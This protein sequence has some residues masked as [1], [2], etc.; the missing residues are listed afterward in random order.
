MAELA[1]FRPAEAL[2]ADE[3]LAAFV[4]HARDD[5][6]VF[7][8]DLD[9]NAPAWELRGVAKVSGRPNTRR[10]SWGHPLKKVPKSIE[11]YAALDDRNVDFFKAYMRYTYGLAPRMSPH[12]TLAAMRLLDKAFPAHIHESPLTDALFLL[13]S[14]SDEVTTT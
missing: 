14:K 7:G 3:R 5:L 4:H 10:V 2:S 8:A 9:W 6:T 1:L 12:Q 13:V 11:H